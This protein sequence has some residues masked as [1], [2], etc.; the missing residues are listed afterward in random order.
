MVL[1][2]VQ[3]AGHVPHDRARPRRLQPEGA[4]LRQRIVQ[5]RIGARVADTAMPSVRETSDYVAFRKMEVY[6]AALEGAMEDGAVSAK[7]REV[8]RRLR[9]SLGITDA[10]ASALERD[11]SPRAA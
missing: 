6:K 8:L 1:P 5:V 11:L 4:C 3:A 2:G 10:D 7:E 9:E